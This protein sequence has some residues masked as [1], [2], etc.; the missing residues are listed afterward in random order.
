MKYLTEREYLEQTFTEECRLNLAKV[1]K[2]RVA[3]DDQYSGWY[4]TLT[5]LKLH[6]CHSSLEVSPSIP[7]VEEEGFYQ[8]VD[9]PDSMYEEVAYLPTTKEFYPC[10][11][12]GGKM[13][14]LATLF[15]NEESNLE[16]YTIQLSGN[17]DYSIS[18]DVIGREEALREWG[19]LFEYENITDEVVS[20]YYFSN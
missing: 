3:A 8:V 5:P 18:F 14:C 12:V 15:Y 7:C 17:D 9:N 16:L 20:K 4:K 6:I 11:W 13:Y 1:I 19:R 2:D 10:H